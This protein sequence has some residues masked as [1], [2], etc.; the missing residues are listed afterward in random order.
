MDRKYIYKYPHPAVAVDCVVFGIVSNCVEILLIQRKSEPF[1]YHWAL[2]GGFVNIDEDIEDAARRELFEETNIYADFLEQIG[3]FGKPDRDP[4]ER[5]ISIAFYTM[6]RTNGMKIRAGSDAADYQWFYIRN[7]PPLAFDH[8]DIIG[9]ALDILRKKV[10]TEPFGIELMPE[11]FRLSQLQNVYEDILNKPIDKR[12]FRKKLFTQQ[13]VIPVGEIEQI[14]KN[15]PAQLYRFNIEKYIE[16]KK[17]R[18]N[19][20]G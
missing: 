4:R 11:K 13:V 8:S 16:L 18:I 2:P 7:L 1:K 10:E 9:H 17:K 6:I 3:A 14:N 19:L 12:N 15:K 20:I 5:V